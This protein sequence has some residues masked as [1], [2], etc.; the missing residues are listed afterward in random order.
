M[1]LAQFLVAR[2]VSEFYLLGLFFFA[3]GPHSKAETIGKE[4][5][6]MGARNA[7]AWL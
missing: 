6:G 5:G 7:P 1:F 2:F 4:E 3:L